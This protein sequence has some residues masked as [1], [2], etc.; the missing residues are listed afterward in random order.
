MLIGLTGNAGSGKDTVAR[1]LESKYGFWSISFAGPIKDMICALLGCTREQLEDRE[2]REQ[3]LSHEVFGAKSPRQLMQTLGTEWGR[4]VVH[5]DIWV[6]KALETARLMSNPNI[7]ITDVRFDNEA[8]AIHDDD[9]IVIRINRKDA[10]A[11]AAH[12]SEA[13]VS[14][15]LIDHNLYNDSTF[16][17]L[18]FQID[19]LFRTF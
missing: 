18:H 11:V 8:F 16:E 19:E 1:Y 14:G 13:G 17:A 10:Q 9:G 6:N 3:P 12:A 4:H 7:V 15:E 2:W 5:K